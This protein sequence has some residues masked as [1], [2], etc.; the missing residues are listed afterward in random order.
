VKGSAGYAEWYKLIIASRSFVAINRKCVSLCP[1]NGVLKVKLLR[2]I[3]ALK[4]N[5]HRCL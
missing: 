2:N 4:S 1:E 5:L 3:M